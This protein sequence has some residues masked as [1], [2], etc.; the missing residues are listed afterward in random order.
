[1]EVVTP[2]QVGSIQHRPRSR[3]R[4][5][6]Y[7]Q[8]RPRA[9]LHQRLG[10]ALTA[11]QRRLSFHVETVLAI[12]LQVCA[13]IVC[14]KDFPGQRR[15]HPPLRHRC[16]DC[17]DASTT[18]PRWVPWATPRFATVVRFRGKRVNGLDLQDTRRSERWV[19]DGSAQTAKP[20]TWRQWCRGATSV[21]SG[22]VVAPPAHASTSAGCR[23][24]PHGLVWSHLAK[25]L[26]PSR[27]TRPSFHPA[28]CWQIASNAS[29]TSPSPPRPAALS[30][31]RARSPSVRGALP[32]LSGPA[33]QS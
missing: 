33:A 5:P 4:C 9:P 7:P 11:G 12:G 17:V 20:R 18:R 15:W 2:D 28:C 8:R 10:A 29:P 13:S 26:T 24:W 30:R 21:Q 22:S 31:S 23:C 25:A 14:A 19:Q 16:H 3:S 27:T 32:A 6:L 1:M